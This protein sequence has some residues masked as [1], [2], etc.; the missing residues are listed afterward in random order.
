MFVL[1]GT[2]VS[3]SRRLGYRVGALVAGRFVGERAERDV[4]DHLA[5]ELQHHVAGVGDLADHR[6]VQLP[7]P[8]DRLGLG[9]RPGFSTISMRSWLSESIIS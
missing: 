8:E 4:A 3:G 7:L 9:S 1:S 5:V 2:F 6:E